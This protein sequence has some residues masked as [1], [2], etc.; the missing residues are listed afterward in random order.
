MRKSIGN[1]LYFFQRSFLRVVQVPSRRTSTGLWR[2]RC[3]SWETVGG[4]RL[5]IESQGDTLSVREWFAAPT[6]LSV[7]VSD[8]GGGSIYALEART[9]KVG[10]PIAGALREAF[11]SS[12]SSREALLVFPDP[13]G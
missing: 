7:V 10:S 6:L 11:C 9:H 2:T 13:S 5:R 12:Q 8:W 3:T 1:R 4:S